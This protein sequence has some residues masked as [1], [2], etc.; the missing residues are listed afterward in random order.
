MSVTV[1]GGTPQCS[2][3]CGLMF[4]HELVLTLKTNLQ[5][6]IPDRKQGQ[7]YQNSRSTG[8][9]Q[10]NSGK[11]MIQD[12]RPTPSWR[13]GSPLTCSDYFIL[14]FWVYIYMFRNSE[15]KLNE[16]MKLRTGIFDSKS[17]HINIPH[18]M[19]CQ[20]KSRISRLNLGQ[21]KT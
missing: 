8:Q 12:L 5:K 18:V 2:Y 10:G 20:I 15:W 11:P 19:N 6:Y 4:T 3:V 14:I 21:Q 13:D 16:I 7:T 17:T 9:G 1:Q